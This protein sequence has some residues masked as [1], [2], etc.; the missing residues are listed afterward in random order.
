MNLLARRRVLLDYLAGAL[1]VLPTVSVVVFLLAG[2]ALSRVEVDQDSPWATLAFQGTADDARSLLIVVSSTMIT[3]TGLVFALTIVALQIASGQY[4]PRL[5]RNFMRDR[6]TQLVLSIFVGAFA[7]STAGL[8]TVGVQGSGQEAFVPRLAVSG[9]LA[10]ALASVGVLIYFIHHLA[11]SIQID[12]IMSQVEREASAVIDEVYPH[13]PGYREAE[14]RCPEPPLVAVGLPSARSGYIQAVDP[15]PL[16]RTAVRHGVVV[17]VARQV[18]DHVVA[19]TPIAWAWGRTA[20]Q[21]PPG[22]GTLREAVDEAVQVGFERTMVQD[23]GFGIRRLVD[24]ANKAL[25]PAVN[26][27]YTGVQA[28]HHLSVLLCSLARLRLGDWIVRDDQGELRVA[29]PRPKFPDYLRLGT[30]QIRRFGA[31]EPAVTRALIVLL[32]DVGTSSA[33]EDRRHACVR[34]IRLVLDD[35]RR[36]TA[37]PADVEA[38]TAEAAAALRLL[39]VDPSDVLADRPS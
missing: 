38:V 39:G 1:W 30:A 31:A 12:T 26:D 16:V 33:T 20:G 4:S 5:L 22:A 35:A 25:S 18:G 23:V 15:D 19:G 9:S 21:P 27:P 36:A 6:G 17:V 32:R 2:A 8:Y 13:Q 11:R 34:H 7:Y 3:V 28:V 29:V 14:E 37:Q 10:L 24:I